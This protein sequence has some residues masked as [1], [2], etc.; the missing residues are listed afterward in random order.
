MKKEIFNIIKLTWPQKQ[1]KPT[2]KHK[3]IYQYLLIFLDDLCSADLQ[4]CDMINTLHS[5]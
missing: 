2:K 5:V 3:H 4:H 1:A